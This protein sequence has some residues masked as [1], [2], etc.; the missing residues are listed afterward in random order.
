[1]SWKDERWVAL[2]KQGSKALFRRGTEVEILNLLDGQM[3]LQHKDVF[4]K[5]VK[6]TE[7]KTLTN[8]KPQYSD[9][10]KTERKPKVPAPDHPWRDWNKK[11]KDK[12]KKPA[13]C[14]EEIPSEGDI[15]PFQKKGTLSL[16]RLSTLPMTFSLSVDSQSLFPEGSTLLTISGFPSAS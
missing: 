11:K 8:L 14:F 1:M 7:E 10:D 13:Y 16:S 3:V 4:Y 12:K 2:Q 5:L 15:S 9:K 6:T